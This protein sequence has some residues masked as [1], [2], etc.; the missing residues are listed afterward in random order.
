L[1]WR[2]GPGGRIRD[3]QCRRC[4]KTQWAWSSLSC[5][6]L[7]PSLVMEM[8]GSS[9]ATTAV[10]LGRTRRPKTQMDGIRSMPTEILSHCDAMFLLLRG[11]LSGTNLAATRRMFNSDVRIVC[12]DQY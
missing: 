6:S 2:S 5:G 7:S 3:E 9:I 10:C 1:C 11:R 4:R 12:T 8:M